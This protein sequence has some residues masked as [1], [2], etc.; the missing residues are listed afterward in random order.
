[1]YRL[2]MTVF[3]IWLGI[4]MLR[5]GLYIKRII[6]EIKT[7]PPAYYPEIIPCTNVYD[8]SIREAKPLYLYRTIDYP[9]PKK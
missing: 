1:M 3:V 2:W 4:L 8:R 7:A 5:S 6:S 9:C